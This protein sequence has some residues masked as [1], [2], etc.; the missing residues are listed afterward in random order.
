MSKDKKGDAAA[1]VG[2][3]ELLDAHYR[4][5]AEAI[6]QIVWTANPDGW[7]DFY[8]QRWFDYTG[9]TLEQTQGWGWEPVLHPDDLQNCILLW[10]HAYSTGEPYETE[11]RFKRAADGEYRWHLGRALPVRD[12]DGAIVKWFGT[13][14]DIHDQKE[15]AEVLR[16]S[17]DELEKQLVTLCAWSN[18]VLYEGEWMTF[19]R[20]LER[21]FGLMTTHGISPEAAKNFTLEGQARPSGALKDPTRLAAVK[22]TGLLDTQPMAGFDRITRLGTA[23]LNVPA[24]FISLVE[25]H[26]DF[27]LSHCGFGEPLASER[28][29][30]GQ[31]FCHFTIEGG[32]PLVIPDTRAD[33]VYA[34]VPTVESLGVAAYLGAPLVLLSGEVIGA[35]CAIDFAPHAWTE[36]EVLAATDLASLVVSEI[37]LRQAALDFQRNLEPAAAIR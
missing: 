8:N 1:A 24:T 5:L 7:L 32:R 9:L 21:R 28:Q 26:R 6:P 16:R 19:S 14:T 36:S 13:C 30:T 10:T 27:Y 15:A 11:Y 20:Y 34:K 37:E 18:T 31:T 22:A 12:A 35:F 2:T 4:T 23:V 25:D 33:P 17:R 3:E 29:L